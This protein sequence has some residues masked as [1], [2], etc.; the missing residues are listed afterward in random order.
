[1]KINRICFIVLFL[2]FGLNQAL[3]QENS[4]VDT[5]FYNEDGLLCFKED[6]K[7]IR[8]RKHGNTIDVKDYNLINGQL[9]LEGAF[10]DLQG[11]QKTGIFKTYHKNGKLKYIVKYEDNKAEGL[12][13]EYYSNGQKWFEGEFFQGNKKGLWKMFDSTG[14]LYATDSYT[15]GI[16]SGESLTY[17]PDGKIKRRE[18]YLDGK[19]DEAKCFTKA[20]KDTTYFPR[21]EMPKFPGG[22]EELYKYLGETIKYPPL[23]RQLEIE[24]KVLLQFVVNKVGK[25]EEIK[26]LSNPNQQLTD[27]A[28]RVVNKMPNWTPGRNEG[29]IVR[30]SFNLP[31][32]F[33]LD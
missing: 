20:G 22:E 5:L 11:T 16:Q 1:M 28:L 9:Q 12:F 33:Q 15:K 29:E 18:F 32:R 4:K 7:T 3:A 23:A 17:Y 14:N 26:V 10:K 21:F 8:V 2:V 6:A 30:V 13:E 24:G 31:I 25:L 27:E 19:I